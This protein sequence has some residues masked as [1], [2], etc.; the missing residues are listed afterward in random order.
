MSA[1]EKRSAAAAPP[2]AVD[3]PRGT[4]RLK[5]HKLRTNLDEA[6]FKLS[7]LALGWRLGA[8]LE[9]DILAA[10]DGRFA[11]LHDATLGPSTTGRGRVTDMPVA[12][13]AGLLHRN[14]SGIGDPDAPVLALADLLTWLRK[15]PRAAGANLQLDLKMLPGRRLADHAVTEIA[16]AASGIENALVIG[17][18]Y[19]DDARRLASALPGARLGYDPMLAASRDPELRSPDRLLRHVE[20]RSAGVTIAYLRYDAV[21]S[22]ERRG[23]SL[24]R[25]LLDI[26]IE[27]DAWTINP[28]KNLGRSE[29]ARVV[30]SRVR[31]IT[32]DA[33][34][35]LAQLMREP[36]RLQFDQ[37]ATIFG[38]SRGSETRRNYETA[39]APRR[40]NRKRDV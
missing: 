39:N 34:S 3:G 30:D 28:G 20:R 32:T 29:L 40:R 36:P 14:G 2:V 13:M 26:G 21:L 27:T 12:R 18:H 19:L 25:K 4:I 10:G 37:P 6:P 35:S 5:W 7:N 11:V 22:A 15:Q 38:S 9:I 33:P 16:E 17:S 31:Q 1:K 8:S 24:V 23:F